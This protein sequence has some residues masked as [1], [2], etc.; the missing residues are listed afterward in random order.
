MPIYDESAAV[1]TP[2]NL[3]R[4]TVHLHDGGRL[5]RSSSRHILRE[6][7]S[8]HRTSR[9]VAP[10]VSATSSTILIRQ[11]DRNRKKLLVVVIET[12]ATSMYASGESNDHSP[13]RWWHNDRP[14]TIPPFRSRPRYCS[15]RG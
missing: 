10:T 12:A 7:G 5:A 8:N 3:G 11:H 14:V 13:D 1:P 9:V 6:A 2:M 4:L 15:E